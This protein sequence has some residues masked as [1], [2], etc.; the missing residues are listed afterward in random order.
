MYVEDRLY[1]N[2]EVPWENAIILK[3]NKIFTL[4][5]LNPGTKYRLRWQAPDSQYPDVEVAT[6]PQSSRRTNPKVVVTKVTFDSFTLSFDHFAPEDY[7]HGYVA[8]Y[9]AIKN[10]RW[11]SQEGSLNTKDLPSITIQNLEPNTDY[12]ARIAI[13]EDFSIR[14]LGKST[15]IINITTTNGCMHEG[16]AVD[17]GKFHVDCDTSCKCYQNGTVTC[18]DRCRPPLHK[19]GTTI[20][21][22]LCVEQPSKED[23]CCVVV[24][25]AGRNDNQEGPCSDIKCGP[26]ARCRHEVFRGD[27][28]ETI[29][30]C[31]EG[32]TGDP[33]STEGCYEQE[34]IEKPISSL[35]CL[36]NNETYSVGQT[37]N[38]GCDY[39]CTCSEKLEILCQVNKHDNFKVA[40]A[41]H[42]SWI[43]IDFF[44]SFRFNDLLGKHFC[45][46]ENESCGIK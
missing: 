35:G 38:D 34:A 11:Q 20:G 14:S 25:C 7:N 6:Q 1:F 42:I 2:R 46:D 13:Y 44:A 22:P 18:G 17:I 27:Q 41:K 29:C 8:L 40:I 45:L 3:G 19:I 36:V 24:T 31:K 37:W 23:E 26:N 39:T 16:Q 43:I 28:A 5:G 33:D 4:T 12:E 10:N 32:F 9:K 15:G 30:V 21:D